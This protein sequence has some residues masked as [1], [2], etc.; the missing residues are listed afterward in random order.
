MHE[1][2]K[3]QGSGG[4]GREGVEQ[5]ALPVVVASDVLDL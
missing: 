1:K 5:R 3:L 4:G 2:E